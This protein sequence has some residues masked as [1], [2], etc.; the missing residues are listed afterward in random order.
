QARLSLVAHRDEEGV[1]LLHAPMRT[2]MLQRVLESLTASVDVTLSVDLDR[3]PVEVFAGRGR[4]AGL[5]LGGALE[6]IL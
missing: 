2:A 4:H 1:D 6:E 3:A 5:E